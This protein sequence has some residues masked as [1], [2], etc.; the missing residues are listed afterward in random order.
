MFNDIPLGAAFEACF[1][2][3]GRTR[4]DMEERHRQQ[5]EDLLLRDA[6]LEADARQL[7]EA[8]FSLEARSSELGH[9]LAAAEGTLASLEAEAERLRVAAAAAGSEK[10][11]REAVVSELR[12]RLRT[13]E[14]KVPSRP[15]R[16]ENSMNIIVSAGL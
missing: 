13:A 10:G 6:A 16:R 14:D 3:A 12:A 4:A 5:V 1:W 7:R 15:S 2:G 9:R 8:K 11:E